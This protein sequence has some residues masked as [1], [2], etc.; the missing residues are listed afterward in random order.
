MTN[1]QQS[2]K[3]IKPELTDRQ[4]VGVE[5]HMRVEYGTLDHLPKSKFRSETRMA[6]LC[7]AEMPG[8]LEMVARSYGM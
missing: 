7:E 4:C 3:A 6:L 5:A 2:I 1:Y 8:Y